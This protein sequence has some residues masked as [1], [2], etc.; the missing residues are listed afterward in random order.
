MFAAESGEEN[1]KNFWVQ[2][3]TGYAKLKIVI[4]EILK[5]LKTDAY[6]SGQDIARSLG[7]TRTA[8]WKYIRGLRN[9]GYQ[10]HSAPRL[11]YRLEKVP[12]LLT[13]EQVQAGLTTKVF[14]RSIHYFEETTSTQDEARRLA[15]HG[16]EEGTLVVAETQSGGRGRRHRHWVSPR[17]M[18]VYLSL[19]LRPELEPLKIAQIPIVTGISVRNTISGVTG[20]EPQTKWPNDIMFGCKKVAGILVEMRAEPGKIHYIIVGIGINVNTPA[21]LFPGD[22]R[23]SAIS[24]HEASG[25]PVY[26]RTLLQ[27]LLSGL[28][29]LY[30]EYKRTG[31][32]PFREQWRRW[33]QTVRSWVFIEDASGSFSGYAMDIDK[34]GAL[35]VKDR[36]GLVRRVS[37][38]DATLR[39]HAVTRMP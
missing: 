16:A 13:P 21:S 39:H 18:G 24:L 7:I 20:L 23:P 10:I 17:G 34:D 31:F 15:E 5:M 27:N 38:G 8:V 12:D 37:A 30:A 22:L 26:R 19:I 36:Q 2:N 1:F 32:E 33:D 35:I 6:T 4:R 28:E 25:R 14:G 3:C 9:K 29:D 11:G